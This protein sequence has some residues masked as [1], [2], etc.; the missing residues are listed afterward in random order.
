MIFKHTFKTPIGYMTAYEEYE[1]II[2]L[3]LGNLHEGNIM[4]TPLLKD[5]E[6]QI[7]QYFSGKRKN[8][9]LPI[10]PQGTDFQK[11]V[12]NKL[13]D[14][15]Y[16]HVCTYAEIAQMCANPKAVRA[17]GSANNK[18]PIMII[19]PCHRVIGKNGNL[20]GYAYGVE[21]KK[22]LLELEKIFI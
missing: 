21:V 18:N 5:T 17:V 9:D 11:N 7:I 19:I 2:R 20:T 1:T 22:R 10:N 3:E 14:I 15:P 16:G 13:L 8:F 12:W 6:N 4:R